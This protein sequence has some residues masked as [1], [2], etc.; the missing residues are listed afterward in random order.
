M[1][2]W[3]LYAMPSQVDSR[4]SQF[5]KEGYA[6][7]WGCE[8][9]HMYLFGCK[10]KLHTDNKGVENILKNPKSNPGA[11]MKRW[12]LRLLQYNFQVVHVE[13]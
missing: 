2:S 11:R 8:K 4:Y 6:A 5:E 1:T 13:G 10:F 3:S 9:Y 12:V 7:V